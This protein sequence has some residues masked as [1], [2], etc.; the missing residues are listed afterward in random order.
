M[1]YLALL[2]LMRTPRLPVVDWTDAPADLKVLIHFAER[3]NLVSSRV[4]SH[5]KR[6]LP[7]PMMEARGS[8]VT[9]PN[10]SF[11]LFK[12]T[13]ENES[14]SITLLSIYGRGFA[15]PS[16]VNA[17]YDRLLYT[18]ELPYLWL[19][20]DNTTVCLGRFAHYLTCTIDGTTSSKPVADRTKG[21]GYREDVYIVGGIHFVSV[22]LR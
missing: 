1:V 20:S 8:S 12:W 3:R 17:Q 4:P 16:L 15:W 9:S 2:P 7:T 21:N 18:L 10:Y 13:D 11:M 19:P 5:F 6:S 14:R 22:F